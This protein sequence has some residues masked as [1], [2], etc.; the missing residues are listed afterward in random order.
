MFKD[1]KAQ[2]MSILS[3]KAVFKTTDETEMPILFFKIRK[4]KGTNESILSHEQLL[5][6][7]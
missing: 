6:S 1:L 2:K 3:E 5:I 7:G 4:G